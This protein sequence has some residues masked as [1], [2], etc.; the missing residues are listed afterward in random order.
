MI[1]AQRR[2]MWPF[3]RSPF[4][5]RQ[6]LT[7]TTNNNSLNLSHSS[8]LMLV[9]TTTNKRFADDVLT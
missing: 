3:I 7:N 9:S 5:K 6:L 1:N 2:C 4:L 8:L